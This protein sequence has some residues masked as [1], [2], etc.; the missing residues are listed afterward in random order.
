MCIAVN[1][2]SFTQVVEQGNYHVIVVTECSE[3]QRP[4]ISMQCSLFHREYQSILFHET[5]HV[6]LCKIL[7]YLQCD[8]T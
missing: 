6:I 1:G 2:D 4:M 7:W 5:Y 3:V 8:T